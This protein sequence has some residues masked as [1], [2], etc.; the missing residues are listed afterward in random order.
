METTPKKVAVIGF[1]CAEPHLIEKH[2]KEGHLPNFKKLFEEGVLAAN[3]LAP[4]PTITPPNWATIA[5]GAWPY[6][7]GITDFHVHI[8][9]NPLEYT[10]SQEA[11]NSN[12]SKAEFIWDALDKA[13]KKS[14]VV[15]YPG[16]WPNHMKNGIVVGGSGLSIGENRDGMQKLNS[17]Q[18]LCADQLVTTGY[19]PLGIKVKLAENKGWKNT[20]KIGAEPLGAAFELLFPAAA[21]KPAPATW[22]ILAVQGKDG[23]DRVALS[24]DN[25]FNHAFFTIGVNEWSKKV[26]TKIKMADASEREVFFRA[27]LV[28][29]SEDAQDL[30][31]LITSLCQTGG[32]ANPPEICQE[33][34]STE[35]IFGHGGGVAGVSVGWFDL[36]TFCEIHELHDL[37]L[38]DTV[39]TLLTKHTW[40][41]FYMHSHPIDWMYHIIMTNMDPATCTNKEAYEKAWAT[42]L[43]IHQSQ[44]KMLGRIIEAA[45]KDTLFVLVS[46]H[47]AVAD[48]APFN[49]HAALEKAGLLVQSSEKTG[50]IAGL[51]HDKMSSTMSKAL[52][53]SKTKDMTKTKAVGQ[54]TVHIYINLKG[55]D[56]EGIVDPADYEKVQQEIIDAMYTYVDPNTGKRP[57]ALALTNQDARIIGL[58]GPDAGDVIYAI[59]PEF[60]GQHGAQLPNA[61]WGIGDLKPLLAI[62]GPGIKKSHRLERSC[63]L[64]DIVPTICYLMDWPVPAQA[65]GSVL[66]QAFKKPNFKAEQINKLKDG[67][68]RMETALQRGERQPWDKHECA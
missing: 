31:L 47:G 40:D 68:A 19:F 11:F 34:N 28:E 9:G 36:D 54:R 10:Y 65:E 27:K 15:N 49:P 56:P 52:S 30:R 2:I 42:H 35:G 24:P 6:T 38:G 46:D 33:I 59:Y 62:S 18:Q 55:R 26:V 23:Y 43:R 21:E 3:C 20:D 8:P 4:F 1:D 13:G 44:D 12:R 66:Y 25:D 58:T 7:H 5:T 16:A 57:V 50:N 37:Y 60:G 67:L 51:D 29:L 39:T 32:W 64:T 41:L 22:Y 61:H 45:G 14:I 63:W 48:G 53:V 17:T